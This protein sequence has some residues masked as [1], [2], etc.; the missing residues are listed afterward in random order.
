MS[1]YFPIIV[2]T[3]IG[4]FV[5]AAVLLVPIYR[6]LKREEEAAKH[7]TPEELARRVREEKVPNGRPPASV[8]KP[9]VS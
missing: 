4:F 3:I 8:R 1:S 9:P 5:L 7:W 2:V 6:F